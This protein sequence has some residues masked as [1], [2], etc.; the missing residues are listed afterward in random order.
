M[1]TGVVRCYSRDENGNWTSFPPERPQ[2]GFQ[3]SYKD[4]SYN[5]TRTNLASI[6]LHAS[7]PESYENFQI[8]DSKKRDISD[9]TL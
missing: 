3:C 6:C 8:H 2:G 4:D 1:N 5:L 9:D 7:R